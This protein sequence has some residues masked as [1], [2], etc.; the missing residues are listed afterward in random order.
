MSRR[1]EEQ[2]IRSIYLCIWG[3][4][5]RTFHPPYPDPPYLLHS[6]AVGG[7]RPR[8]VVAGAAHKRH[9]IP[10]LQKQGAKKVHRKCGRLNTTVWAR[11]EDDTSAWGM[12]APMPPT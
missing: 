11:M 6:G 9:Q 7:L 5:R 1:I 4:R 10:D 2:A 12:Y 8:Q 3:W